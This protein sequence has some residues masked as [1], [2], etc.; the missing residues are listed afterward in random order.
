[1]SRPSTSKDAGSGLNASPA[2]DASTVTPAELLSLQIRAFLDAAE[3][4]GMDQATLDDLLEL[5]PT[6]NDSDSEMHEDQ[7]HQEVQAHDHHDEELDL[8]CLYFNYEG[9]REGTMS[10]L[11]TPAKCR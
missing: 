5:L 6:P 7:V 10:T 8:S 1:M 9:A 4:V 3:D 11:L 2:V